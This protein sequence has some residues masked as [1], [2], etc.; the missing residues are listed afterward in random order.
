MSRSL[1]SVI[2]GCKLPHPLSGSSAT[3][4]F[5]AAMSC[6]AGIVQAHDHTA[7]WLDESK[8]HDGVYVQVRYPRVIRNRVPWKLSLVMNNLAADKDVRIERIRYVLPGDAGTVTRSPQGLLESKQ[9]EFRDFQQVRNQ[10]AHA[11]A[12]ADRDRAAALMTE[13]QRLTLEIAS[14]T[15]IDSQEIDKN[16]IPVAG[17]VLR[18]V[19]EIELRRA[20]QLQTIREPIAIPVQPPLPGGT[21]GGCIWFAG[22]QHIH[23]RYSLDAFLLDGTNENVIDYATSAELIGMDWIIITDHSNIQ[24]NWFG[25]QFYSQH[26]FNEAE[27]QAEQYRNTF[28]Y[29]VLYSQEMG[30]GQS[31]FLSFPAHYLAYPYLAN[32][33]GFMPNPSSGFIFNFAFCE[34]QQVIIDR[35]AS[36]GGIGF[37]AHPFDSG[38]A[39][40]NWDFSQNDVGWSGIEIFNSSEGR[41]EAF[42]AQGVQKWYELLN[43]IDAPQNGQL[44]PRPGFPNEFP[45]GIGNSDAHVPGDIGQTFTYACVQSVTR[46][47]VTEALLRG[48]C[49][50][51]NGPLVFGEINGA[52][53]G[54]VT[55]LQNGQNELAVTLQTTP[56][57]GPVG[58][59]EITVNVDGVAR[60]VI[61][62]S[63]SPA[64]T[65][66]IVLQD[67]LSAPDKFVNIVVRG[68]KELPSPTP[69]E[70]LF[71]TAITNPIWLEFTVATDV[72]LDGLVDFL[73]FAAVLFEMHLP[74]GS[75]SAD[76]N[77]DSVVN[78]SDLT[79]VLT[80]W[81]TGA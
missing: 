50:A 47:N 66:T 62:P 30:A 69:D 37:I 26:Q 68:E 14:G 73:D 11:T 24:F 81:L 54:E 32:S 9:A 49:V 15:F 80:D 2:R 75:R 16:L 12:A 55:R 40:A 72:N 25:E 52:G 17:S 65:E 51:T 77:R 63:G 56:E 27:S 58:Q 22:D 19:V 71:R 79:A 44:Q 39:F 7:R 5:L 3:V 33:T 42:N 41:F 13:R 74:A 4:L 6:L 36:R 43:E 59:Y 38:L 35:V 1:D 34:P 53:I 23:T 20:D 31:P 18:I 78:S 46:E 48:R 8:L 70:P 61:P 10:L 21:P 29:L 60:T 45:V 28:Q 76:V 64:F 67:L 57:F